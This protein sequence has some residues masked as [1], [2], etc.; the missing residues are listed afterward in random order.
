MKFKKVFF[1]YFIVV[2]FVVKGQHT[3]TNPILAGFYPDPSICKANGYYYMVNSTFA[4]FPGIPVFRSKDLVNWK[5]IGNVLDRPEQLDLEGLG[6][7][8]GIFAPTIHYHQGLFYVTCTIVDG[9][10]NFVVTSTNPEGPWSNP[11]WIPE[12]E[13]IDPSMFFDANGK[14]YILY[15]SGPPN[16]ESLYDGHRTIKM[17][18]FDTKKMQVIGEEKILING[19]TDISKKP[20][21]IEG[22]HMYY[23]NEYYYLIAAEGGTSEEHSEVVFR[24]KNIWGPYKSYDENPILTQR[25]LDSNRQYPITSTGHADIIETKNGDWYGFF[26]GCRPYEDNFYNTGRETFMAPITWENDW[27]RFDLGTKEVKY[28][29]PTPGN[30]KLE[31]GNISYSNNFI[32]RDQFEDTVLGFNWLFLRTP[33]EKWYSLDKG[34]LK[35]KTRAQS[36]SGTGNPSFIGHRQQHSKGSVSVKMEF[37]ATQESEKSGLLVFQNESHY[38]YLCTSIKNNKPVIQVFKSS[39][40]S[41]EEL[42]SQYLS[43]NT[44]IK[45][46]IQANNT[47]YN[48]LYAEQNKPWKILID[49]VDARFLSTK[50]AGGFV[51]CIY[52]MYTTSLGNK[53][54]NYA[55]FDWFEYV[56]NDMVY[57]KKTKD[58]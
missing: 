35:M 27:P 56:G 4:Y 41:L 32:F 19:G 38:Y 55:L 50:V 25:D 8:R 54:E 48:F 37:K 34:K 46:K 13:G 10:N 16:D 5:Q 26:L 39:G 58:E 53:T 28:K 21:W 9:K 36:C 33:K 31:K 51:G 12:V 17:Y 45:L 29:Y 47:S 6:V 22:P 3:Y 57:N 30:V 52:G 42:A 2:C 23:R 18:E 24:S 15:N 49:N 43:S 1:L 14:S 44:P 40:K 11:I 20:V 7:S